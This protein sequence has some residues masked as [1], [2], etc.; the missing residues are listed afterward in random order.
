MVSLGSVAEVYTF[1]PRSQLGVKMK[2]KATQS[3]YSTAASS[4]DLL[5]SRMSSLPWAIGGGMVDQNRRLPFARK[6][7]LDAVELQQVVQTTSYESRNSK[8]A[9]LRASTQNRP[10]KALAQN[11]CALPGLV[12]AQG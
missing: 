4:S 1:G 11:G 6:K 5:V 7:G 2:T 8:C 10:L 9:P 3:H 12:H